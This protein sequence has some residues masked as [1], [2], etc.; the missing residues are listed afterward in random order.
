MLLEIIGLMLL[1]IIGLAMRI[2]LTLNFN[3][4]TLIV[5]EK[6]EHIFLHLFIFSNI[7]ATDHGF[8]AVT[9]KSS[10]YFVSLP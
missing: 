1:E 9:I 5:A 6:F 4:A 7:F 2:E 10:Q 3:A 8:D